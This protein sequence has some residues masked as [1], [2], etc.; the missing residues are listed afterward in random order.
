VGCSLILARLLA[1]SFLWLTV[2]RS[3]WGEPTQPGL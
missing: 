3:L 1:T 2:S